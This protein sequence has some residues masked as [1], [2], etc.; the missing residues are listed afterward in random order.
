MTPP[1]ARADVVL[2]LPRKHL[3]VVY[4]ATAIVDAVDGNADFPD[5]AAEIPAARAALET[6][7]KAV[8]DAKNKVPGAVPVRGEAKVALVRAFQPLR[9][10]V[11][12]VVDAHLDQAE[13]LVASARMK[14]RRFGLRTKADFTVKDG[15]LQGQV[16]L[17][18]RAV[19]GALL[20]FWEVRLGDGDW[21]FACD[22]SAS[23]VVISD[24][25][26][27]QLYS[28]RFRVRTRAGMTDASRVL[29]R[30]VR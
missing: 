16:H 7:A 2:G 10:V 26:V 13:T 11:Q 20:Y 27:G 6:Y 30:R 17:Y 28:F 5:A 14:I 15:P 19:A 3:D 21:T 18:A 12:S 1:P 24:L 9:R 23:D 25:T 29:T 22:T 4:A 8:T